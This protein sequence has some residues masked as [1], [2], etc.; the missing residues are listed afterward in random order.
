MFIF[1]GRSTKFKKPSER[2]FSESQKTESFLSPSHISL[3]FFSVT[4]I[5]VI[6]VRAQ[7]RLIKD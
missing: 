2:L 7:D 6:Q 4:N 3:A 1:P 5:F